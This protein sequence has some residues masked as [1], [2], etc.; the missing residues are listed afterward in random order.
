MS[1]RKF[2]LWMRAKTVLR[3]GGVEVMHSMP[4]EA[5]KTR[6]FFVKKC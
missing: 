4:Q 1:Y 3:H 2:Y 5:P 6:W